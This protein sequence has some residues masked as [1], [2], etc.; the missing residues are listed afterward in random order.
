MN[1]EIRDEHICSKYKTTNYT[2]KRIALYYNL[3]PQGVRNILLKNLGKEEIEKIKQIRKE[4][5]AEKLKND[6]LDICQEK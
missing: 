5:V 4:K 1:K 2:I 3:S 6:Y